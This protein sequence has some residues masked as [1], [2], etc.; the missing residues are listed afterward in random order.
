MQ[1]KKRE[2]L[3]FF[4]AIY[5]TFPRTISRL[6]TRESG[7]LDLRIVRDLT[8]ELRGDEEENYNSLNNKGNIQ[9]QLPK[10]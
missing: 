4:V 3:G 10:T 8:R 5:I 9:S 2:A 7:E 1:A 6:N